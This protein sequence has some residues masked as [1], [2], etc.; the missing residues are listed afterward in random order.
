MQLVVPLVATDSRF[1]KS[2]KTTFTQ[3]TQIIFS[4][5]PHI[6]TAR[7]TGGIMR[8]VLVAL[9]PAVICALWFFGIDALWVLVTS[10]ISCI[11]T[12]WLITRF[13]LRRAASLSDCSA[14]LTGVLLALTLPSS[15]PLWMVAAGGIIAIGIA[16]M[17]FGGLGCNIF[18]PALVG[19][20]FLLI[21][22]PVAMTTWPLPIGRFATADGTT[23]AT[24]LSQ[25]KTGIANSCALDLPAM[26]AGDMGGS[27]GEVSTGALLL[28]F[29]YLLVLKIIKWHIPVSI[30][31]GLVLVDLMAGFPPLPDILSGGLLL[32]AVFMATDYV[33]SPMTNRGKLLYGLMIGI[34]TAV[35]RR[36]GSYPE[37]I[38][39][40]ILIMNGA[41]PLI[42]RY[43]HNTRFSGRRKEATA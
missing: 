5:S 1:H 20:V 8:H 36:W 15:L 35:I 33:T 11:A 29:V 24:I 31:A 27:I 10:V 32:G 21:S 23:G 17:A 26:F 16:K 3:M 34:I 4:P 2:S 9:A 42:N 43:M 38:S 18:N 14:I 25:L 40:A 28:G 7:T 30:V 12:E 6:H 41:T 39:F 37:G 22:F 13:M 19:R